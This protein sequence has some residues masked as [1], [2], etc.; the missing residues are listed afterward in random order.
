MPLSQISFWWLRLP[1]P[2]ATEQSEGEESAVPME[3][4]EHIK[5]PPKSR[6]QKRAMIA[7]PSEQDAHP[8]RRIRV[9]N[10]EVSV[11]I[12]LKLFRPTIV[13]L[14]TFVVLAKRTVTPIVPVNLLRRRMQEP[15]RPAQKRSAPVI[16]LQSGLLI[17]KKWRKR[18]NQR[19]GKR[20]Q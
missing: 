16:R 3:E 13:T 12:D 2:H 7:S 15:V 5:T 8:A 17:Q 1:A 6:A 11:H 10:P 4:D 14:S 18:R 19:R 9:E 20:S